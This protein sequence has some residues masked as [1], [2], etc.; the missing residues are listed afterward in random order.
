MLA[1]QHQRF[2][3]EDILTVVQKII[4]VFIRHRTIANEGTN[5]LETGF[6]AIAQKIWSLELRTS[7]DVIDQLDQN[8][9][10]SD[11]ETESNFSQLQKES[12]Q[13]AKK[14]TLVYLLS[15]LYCGV[16]DDF[17]NDDLYQKVFDEDRYQPMHIMEDRQITEVDYLGNWTIIEK[18]IHLEEAVSQNDVVIKLKRSQLIANEMLAAKIERSGWSDLEINERQKKLG[19][20][21]YIIW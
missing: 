20:E 12:K 8:L 18:E 1:M 15:E 2:S 10:K 6:A 21:V 7:Q 19:R 13:G 4:S 16:Y 14:W 17:N 5:V 3:E 11:R 9:L